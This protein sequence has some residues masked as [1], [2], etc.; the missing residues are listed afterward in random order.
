MRRIL[1]ALLLLLLA[2]C[3]T[4]NHPL[5]T[6]MFPTFTPNPVPTRLIGYYPSWVSSRGYLPSSIPAGLLTH[7]FYAFAMPNVHGNCVLDNPT[8][9]EDNLPGLTD[10]RKLNPALKIIL[11]IGGGSNLDVPFATVTATPEAMATFS[12]SCITLLTKWGL[13]GLDLDWEFPKAEQKQAYTALLTEMRR[14]LN[15]R[16]ILDGRP[17]L[18]TNAVPAGPWAMA[19]ME[20]AK[21]TPLLDW[22]NLMTYDFYGTWSAITGHNA[23]LLTNPADPQGLSADTT[24]L[25]YLAAGVPSNKLVL[26]VPFYGRAWEGAGSQ[27]A[28]LFQTYTGPFMNHTMEYQ[29]IVSKY[30][31]TF[32]RHWDD[33]SKV[34]WLY[35]PQGQV[36]ISYD[37][38][39]SLRLKAFYVRQRALG[40]MMIWQLAGDDAQHTLL[41]TLANP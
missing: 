40:G 4:L 3:Q 11:S 26:G 41:N 35:D 28:G 15:Q 14:Q 17:Y 25:A 31:P 18:L 34:P 27:N 29:E 21:V 10:L 30:L 5:E 20:I 32:E 33:A 22:Y 16:A 19:R 7:I 12:A 37:D 2:A 6:A 24:V 39:D 9:A 8:A 36:I 38:S 23:P 1:T 13:D